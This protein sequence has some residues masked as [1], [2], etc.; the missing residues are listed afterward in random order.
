VQRLH[1]ERLRLFELGVGARSGSAQFF[2]PNNEAHVSGALTREA[3]LG[4][5][6]VEV[7]VVTLSQIFELLGCHRI[8]LLKLDIEGT[9][10]EVI[11]SDDFRRRASGIRQLCI[12]F[13]H[14]W[15]GRGK[16]ATERAVGLL[17][18]LG[19][20]CAWYA[21]STNEEFLFVNTGQAAGERLDSSAGASKQRSR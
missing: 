19:F 20:Q 7:Q 1:N 6:Q 21:P 14:R 17:E 15:P 3:H 8:D 10:Y 12:E 18:A 13:H 2:L 16:G 9:E 4:R 5:L 11:E